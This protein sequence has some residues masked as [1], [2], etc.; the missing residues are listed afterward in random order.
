MK[1]RRGK[2][3]DFKELFGIMN[4]SP[5]LQHSAG[6]N[7]YNKEWVISMLT[8]KKRYLSL[9]AEENGEIVGFL[10]SEIW[11]SEKYSFILEVYVMPR[12]RN[13][14][15]ATALFKEHEMVCRKMRMKDIITS[16]LTSNK[17]MMKFLGSNRY[18]KGT[19]VRYFEK[20]LR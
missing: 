14:G 19:E 13:N 15:I 6:G 18:V 7:S 10:T 12:H 16:T 4:K 1:I 17:R 11:K 8:D 20:R 2:L 5:E 9:I 3:R